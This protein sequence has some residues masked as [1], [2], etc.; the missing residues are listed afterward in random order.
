MNSIKIKP[1][2]VL[3][4]CPAGLTLKDELRIAG[5]TLENPQG[6][7]V[8][9]LAV[10][11]F[12]IAVWGLQAGERFFAHASCPGC[13]SD[14]ASENRVVFLLGH[15]D[16]WE[17]SQLISEYLRLSKKVVESESAQRRKAEAIAL[18]NQGEYSQATEV[19]RSAL[20]DLR[21]VACGGGAQ[22]M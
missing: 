16:K 15:Q 12:P 14:L 17:L 2:E 1:I 21:R 7:E 4:D 10:C 22:R 6:S 8:C 11:H 20:K 5:M 9:F 13:T 19:M 3:G 18:Q